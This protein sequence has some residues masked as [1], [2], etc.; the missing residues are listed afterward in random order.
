MNIDEQAANQLINYLNSGV[1]FAVTQAPIIAQEILNW[2][3]LKNC[4][5]LLLGLIVLIVGCTVLYQHWTEWITNGFKDI[6]FIPGAVIALGLMLSLSSGF[7]LIKLM[8]APKLVLLE[9][10]GQMV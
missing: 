8:V 3:L 10:I 7:M 6:V 5:M 2:M 9:V 1:D 4:C